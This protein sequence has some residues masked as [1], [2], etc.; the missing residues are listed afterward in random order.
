MLSSIAFTCPDA[1]ELAK[2]VLASE[3]LGKTAMTE[4][5]H[6]FQLLVPDTCVLPTPP[7]E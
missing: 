1:T 3:Q 5:I 2:T 4:I 7:F 6:E